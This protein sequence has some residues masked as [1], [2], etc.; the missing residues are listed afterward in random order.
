MRLEGD[1]NKPC[2]DVKT[3]QGK[4]CEEDNLNTD[5]VGVDCLGKHVSG[6]SLEV[7]SHDKDKISRLPCGSRKQ[8]AGLSDGT[9]G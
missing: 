7:D 9:G 5:S 4:G 3:T 8:R 2:T 6:V 1:R